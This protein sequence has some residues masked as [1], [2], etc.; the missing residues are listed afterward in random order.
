MKKLIFL[1]L[2]LLIATPCFAQDWQEARMNLGV[3]SGGMPASCSGSAKESNEDGAT[4]LYFG[5]ASTEVYQSG[6]ITTGS[7]YTLCKIQLSFM[8]TGAPNFTFT[9][10]LYDNN[11][12]PSDRPG[13]V[14]A[15]TTRADIDADVD[16]TTSYAWYDFAF[17]NYSL[18]NATKYWIVIVASGY[19]DTS[20]YVRWLATTETGRYAPSA[21]GTTWNPAT[22]TNINYR[23]YAYE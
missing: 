3:I 9:V 4:I 21:D 14:L 19:H 18:S 10:K 23:T 7:A 22:G 20:N 2:L 11:P 5:R 6:M 1:L 17:T 16:L 13:S 8:R 15:T 12:T